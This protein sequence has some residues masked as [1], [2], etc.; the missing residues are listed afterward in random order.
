MDT[1]NLRCLFSSL[2]SL[3]AQRSNLDV[4]SDEKR[5]CRA[6][7]AR[8]DDNNFKTLKRHN[9]RKVLRRGY[10]L[11]AALLSKFI[12]LIPLRIAVT[13]GGLLGLAAYYV[14]GASRRRAILNLS[15]AFP[16]KNE[17]EIRAMARSVF[18]N[19]GKNLFELFSFPKLSNDKMLSLCRISNREIMTEAFKKGKGVLIA[20]AHCANWEMMGATLSLSGFPINVIAR[21]IYIEELNNMLVNLRLSKGVRVILRSGKESAREILRSLRHNEAIGILIDQDTAVP[22]VFV[23]F[24]GKKAWTPSGLATLAMRTGASVVLALDVRLPD[25]SHEVVLSGP[26]DFERTGNDEA[27]IARH[28][29]LITQKIEDHIRVYPGQWVWMHDRWKTR[30][31]E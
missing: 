31:N 25:D 3:R 14:T 22:G 29:Q 27:D 2:R 28:V 18:L 15:A 21:R 16:G 17:V 24:F 4:A 1:F 19:Q 8:N 6:L 20:S 12:L 10:Y 30:E 26:F 5:D 23:D 11:L 7:R 9:L 13:A